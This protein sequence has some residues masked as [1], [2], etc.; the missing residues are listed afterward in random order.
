MP[1]Q[2][3]PALWVKKETKR[4]ARLSAEFVKSA[5]QEQHD[6]ASTMAMDPAISMVPEILQKGVM[7]TK[8]LANKQ[9]RV[10]FRLDPDEGRILYKSI[11]HGMVCATNSI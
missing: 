11:K 9:K 10:V 8:V 2:H 7:M 1:S 3:G 6:A 4:L 5:M